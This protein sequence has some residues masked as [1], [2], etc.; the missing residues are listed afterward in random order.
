MAESSIKD[1]T[2]SLT[3][4][5]QFLSPIIMGIIGVVGW[6]FKRMIGKM[7]DS[8]E[9]CQKD[10]TESKTDYKHDLQETKEA[11]RKE[12]DDVKT[13]IRRVEDAAHQCRNTRSEQYTEAINKIGK[14][15]ARVSKVEG[16]LG[17]GGED[18]N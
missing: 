15:G 3:T 12:L 8:V 16:R 11:F 13:N 18:D 14:L 4:L 6:M 17:K 7:E 9:D 5:V 1:V 2:F 10:I